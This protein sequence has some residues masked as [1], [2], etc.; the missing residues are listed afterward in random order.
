MVKR[1]GKT[2]NETGL[3]LFFFLINIFLGQNGEILHPKR[4][5]FVILENVL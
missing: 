3:P 5:S 1:W 4:L 2:E